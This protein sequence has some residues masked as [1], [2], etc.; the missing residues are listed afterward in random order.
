LEWGRHALIDEQVVRP[1]GKALNV[2]YALAWMGGESVAAG[3]WGRDDYDEMK[4]AI[5][6]LNGRI[7][8]RMTAAA[9][10]TR[11]NITVVDTHHQREMHL[12]RKSELASAD[13]LRQLD[14]DLSTLVR[15]GDVCVFAGAMPV[16][17][18]LEPTVD[19][20]RTCRHAGAQI[21]VDTY[22]PA[23]QNMVEARLAWLIAP[24][25]EELRELLGLPVEDTPEKLAEAGRRL[26]DRM[27]MVLISRGEKGA[28]VVAKDG[29]WTGHSVTRRAVLSTVGCGDYLLAGFLAGVRETGDPCASLVRGVKVATARAWG[30]TD[31][32]P[33]VRAEKEIAVAVEEG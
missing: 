25:V 13:S 29:V 19:L 6:Q 20:V 28:L 5:D 22:G 7:E 4:R 9:G 30:W 21:V 15:A 17:E 8:A 18:L 26:L 10:R 32:E 14:A 12:R 1:A 33:W 24:N 16:G 31:S 27:D 11:Q 23:L 2:S 3:L